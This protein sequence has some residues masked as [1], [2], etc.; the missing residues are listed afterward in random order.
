MSSSP[1]LGAM[2]LQIDSAGGHGMAR[3]D[4]V[5]KKLAA[6]MNTDYNIELVRQPCPGYPRR[7]GGRYPVVR[8]GIL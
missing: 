7:G 2:K 8:I 4:K 1:V 5:F 6:M 3:G